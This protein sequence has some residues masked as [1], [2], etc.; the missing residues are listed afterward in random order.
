MA[1]VCRRQ[2]SH[3]EDR[4]RCTQHINYTVHITAQHAFFIHK[5][6]H[7]E[8]IKETCRR[9]NVHLHCSN[10]R[11]GKKGQNFKAQIQETF[12]NKLLNYSSDN[13]KPTFS[14]IFRNFICRK[15]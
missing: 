4:Y 3:R 11:H 12:T 2:L 5:K 7:N 14:V 15:S 9:Q 8:Q 1:H 13:T 6:V 10:V